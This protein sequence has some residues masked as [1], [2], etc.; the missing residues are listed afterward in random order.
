MMK[1]RDWLSLLFPPTCAGCGE[2]WKFQGFDS[3]APSL[4]CSRCQRV[5]ESERLDTCGGCGK[6]VSL[7]ECLTKDLFLARCASF[8]K[9]VFYRHGKTTALQN[10]LIYRIKNTPDRKCTE[11]FAREMTQALQD[12]VTQG[13]I[14]PMQALL[15]YVPR[16]RSEARRMGTDQAKA[17]ARAV[18]RQTGIPVR[19]ALVRCIGR[20]KQQK[21]LGYEER[22]KNA[23]SSYRLN[24]KVDL[25]GKTVV[26]ID[27]IVT[28]GVSM[29]A[30]AR[31]LRRAGADRIFCLAVSAD[32]RNRNIDLRQP[33]FR[34]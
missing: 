22:R 20:S 18:S 3:A 9:L 27:D 1:A 2:R 31:I 28:T 34:I 21:K 7:C 24:R 33:T 11:F 25:S 14:D 30:G 32:D 13:E 26:L 8:R 15:V 5:W 4:L 19:S 12:W 23:K 29:A 10:K 16:G 17:L 6:A